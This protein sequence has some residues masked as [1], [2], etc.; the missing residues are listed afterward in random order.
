MAP[1]TACSGGSCSQER[2]ISQS[3]DYSWRARIFVNGVGNGPWSSSA[4][5]TLNLPTLSAPTLVAPL[6]TT[7]S[8]ALVHFTWNAVSGADYYILEVTQPNSQVLEYWVAPGSYCS[9]SICSQDRNLSLS[10]DYSWRA[11]IFVNGIGNGPWSSSAGFTLNL[12]ALSAP[13]LVAPAGTSQTQARVSF[14]W[15][16]VSQADYY[17]LEVTQPDSQLLEY[18]V[19]PGSYCSGATCSQDRILSQSGD[20]SWR[21]RI[22]VNGIGYGPWSG[23]SGFTLNLAGASALSLTADRPPLV[24]DAE[25]GFQPWDLLGPWQIDSTVTATGQGSSWHIGTF[26]AASSLTWQQP[27]DLSGS[28]QPTLSFSAW[29]QPPDA[30][31][32]VQLSLDGHSWQV[33]AVI[34]PSSGW[35]PL[36]STSAPGT[37]S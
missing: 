1:A 19:A 22:F 15:N 37:R 29:L 5:F 3:G 6:G 25:A 8:Q 16:A 26:D 35:Q 24:L 10:G 4:S 34:P 14:T 33:I 28:Q 18:W 11:R 9:G 13:T 31:A 2:N 17:I 7:Q 32:A 27:I 20:Y 36:R 23:S 30:S 12:P 21:A